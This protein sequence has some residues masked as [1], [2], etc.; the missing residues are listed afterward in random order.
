MHHLLIAYAAVTARWAQLTDKNNSDRGEGPVSTAVVI[1]VAAAAAVAL[2]VIIM[3][4][5]NNWG[6]KIPT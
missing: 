4:A 2:G 1:A 5:V 6:S 3:A